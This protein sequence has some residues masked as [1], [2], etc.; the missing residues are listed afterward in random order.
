MSVFVCISLPLR[1]K[2]IVYKKRSTQS[3]GQKMADIL[4]CWAASKSYTFW[5]LRVFRK[6][7]HNTDILTYNVSKSKLFCSS[8]GSMSLKWCE[9]M[10]F[11]KSS[12]YSKGCF[13]QHHC[14]DNRGQH[15]QP[16][17]IHNHIASIMQNK[18]LWCLYRRTRETT[19][20]IE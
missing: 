1:T 3:K 10:T 14:Y 19:Q 6:I 20:E 11:G 2:L 7:G 8:G 15:Q 5:F 12:I 9:N 18:A 4:D 16:E 17:P 13:C